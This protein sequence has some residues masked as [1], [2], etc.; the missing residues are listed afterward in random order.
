MNS[1]LTD[2]IIN[3]CYNPKRNYFSHRF[4]ES[5][6]KWC[7]GV[8]DPYSVRLE[9]VQLSHWKRI[10]SHT[11]IRSQSNALGSTCSSKFLTRVVFYDKGSALLDGCV[12]V[13]CVDLANLAKAV[14]ISLSHFN[15]FK[16]NTYWKKIEWD[17]STKLGNTVSCY[18]MMCD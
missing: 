5:S 17:G 11:R 16:E 1:R 8:N 12:D 3:E 15:G 4:I 7:R 10:E 14:L 6:L 13:T 9:G 18:K 2:N